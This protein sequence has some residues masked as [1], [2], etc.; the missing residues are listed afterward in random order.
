M[1]VRGRASA[2]T[3]PILRRYFAVLLPA[4]L[5]WEFAHM[6]LY[7]LWT[8][9]TWSEI[10]FAGVHCTGGDLLIAGSAL[11]VSLILLGSGWPG[12]RKAWRRVAILTLAIGLGYTI[13]SEWLNTELRQSWSYAKEMPVLPLIGTGLSP[14]LQWIVVPLLALYWAGKGRVAGR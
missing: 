2:R 5:L 6:P 13:F 4:H 14:F 3:V 12:D 10:L 9:G 1:I 7:T 8:E 11:I